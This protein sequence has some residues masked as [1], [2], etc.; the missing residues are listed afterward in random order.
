[1]RTLTIR[2]ILLGSAG[3][4][5]KHCWLQSD[6]ALTRTDKKN[7]FCTDTECIFLSVGR[8]FQRGGKRPLA[9]DFAL[10][11]SSVLCLS[12]DWRE[13]V[14]HRYGGDRRF[15]RQENEL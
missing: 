9:H 13:N 10:A 15:E 6:G 3:A 8:G 7:T 4:E 2:N 11:K 1:M 12:T 14:R 5:C